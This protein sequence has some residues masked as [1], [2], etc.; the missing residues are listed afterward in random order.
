MPSRTPVQLAAAV[1]GAGFL[2]VGVLGFV[3][4]ITTNLADITFAGHESGALLLG[5]FKVSVL[6]NIAHLLFGVGVLMARTP[7]GART[8]LL[9]AGT[10]YLVLTVYGAV[11]GH[12]TALNFLPVNTAD[13]WL[14]LGLGV[15]MVGAGAALGERAGAGRS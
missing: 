4:G 15:A 2:L 8:Y 9:G 1:A 12:D 6:H 14:H 13:N 11:I 7:T 10:A 3:P 5:L